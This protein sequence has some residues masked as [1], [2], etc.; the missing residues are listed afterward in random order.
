MLIRCLPDVLLDKAAVAAAARAGLRLRQAVVA[1]SV[2]GALPS[3]D[4]PS[5]LPQREARLQLRIAPEGSW[6]GR[7]S[8]PG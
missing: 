1:G 2:M 8:R 3:P 4:Q 7:G 6:T 5:H